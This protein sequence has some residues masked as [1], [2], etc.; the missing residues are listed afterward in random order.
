MV[1]DETI[2]SR[3]ILILYFLIRKLRFLLM[4][5]FGMD[6][7]VEI[8]NQKTIKIIGIKREKKILNT[9]ERLPNTLKRE[10]GRLFEFGSA[11]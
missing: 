7:T 1:G 10:V 9:T 3:D 4:A 5:A 11:N 2:K 6:M 8:P